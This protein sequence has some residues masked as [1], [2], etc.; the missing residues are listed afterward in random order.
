MSVSSQ[1]PETAREPCKTRMININ[2]HLVTLSGKTISKVTSWWV[3]PI[4]KIC[5]SNWIIYP[6]R[7]GNRNVW[8]HHLDHKVWTGTRNITL[9]SGERP[10]RA[11]FV[12]IHQHKGR[13]NICLFYITKRRCF[14]ENMK[15][16]IS[17]KWHVDPS[18]WGIW[19]WLLL[20]H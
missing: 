9:S 7:G 13:E 6:G 4:R 16:M 20:I 11:T 1:S 10:H 8:N 14:I 18:N 3:Q 5:S 17:K 19:S 2:I 12:R 15:N